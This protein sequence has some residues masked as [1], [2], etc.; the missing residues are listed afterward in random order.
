MGTNEGIWA[1]Y[2]RLILDIKYCNH[3]LAN[4]TQNNEE[5]RYRA[6][7]VRFIRA[8]HYFYS[9]DLYLYAPFLLEESSAFP[10]FQARHKTYA[11][12]VN[13]LEELI[14]LLPAERRNTYRVGKAAAQLLLARVYLNADVYNKY[15]PDWTPGQMWEK[16]Y[17]MANATIEDNKGTHDLVKKDQKIDYSDEGGYVYSAYQQLFMGDNNRPE[18]CKEAVLQLYQDGM[19]AW[20]YAGA[21][22]LVKSVRDDGMVPSGA[23]SGPWHAMRTSPTLI[24][25][26]I[27]LVG[28]GRSQAANMVYDES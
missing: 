10:H 26:F 16:A 15:N 27:K 5:E 13:E 8:L 9:M 1:I 14:T 28:I 7:E 18:I 17:D 3:Y 20:S 25:K 23:D 19:Y 4:A 2:I 11:W 22:F 12:L 24:D 21:S 6:A